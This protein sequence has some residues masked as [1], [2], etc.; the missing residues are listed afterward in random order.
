[1][2]RILFAAPKKAVELMFTPHALERL[3]GVAELV[4]NESDR[5]FT[6]EEKSKALK[7]VDV[8]ISGWHDSPLTPA[9][10]EAANRLKLVVNYGQSISHQSPE[11]AMDKGIK[12]SNAGP[13][14]ARSVAEFCVGL[15]LAGL[16]N[17]PQLDETLKTQG[18]RATDKIPSGL[19]VLG[20]TLGFVGFGLIGSRVAELMR[21][22]G[23]EY[24]AYDPFVPDER[25][26][27][28]GARRVGLEEL[29]E[30]SDI[31]TVHV[32]LTPETRGLIGAELLNRLKLGALLVNTA[33]AHVIEE[34]PLL[35][36]AQ[37]G[38]IRVALDVYWKEPLPD[39]SPWRQLPNVVLTP[40]RAGG[41]DE[42][43]VKRMG[44][45]IAEDVVAF[46]TEGK[47]PRGLVTREKLALMT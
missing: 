34:A 4:F 15:I 7:D 46:L 31:V 11:F 32:G 9:N 6:E 5:T 19:D 18:F 21:A 16:R 33:R 28:L 1:M 47:L 44:E 3:A 35:K 25:L 43:M 29:F 2:A 10:Y 20:K 40:H 39:D 22:F 30:K 38:R 24:I 12:F 27:A 36:L 23:A 13:E 42:D 17:I 26:E 45:F 14:L 37:E 8:V 41:R